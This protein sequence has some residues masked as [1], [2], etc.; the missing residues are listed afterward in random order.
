LYSRA[1]SPVLPQIEEIIGP[2]ASIDEQDPTDTPM[3]AEGRKEY[4]I[5]QLLRI[6]QEDE[7]LT[8]AQKKKEIQLIIRGSQAAF[9]D[10]E[11]SGLVHI[12]DDSNQVT[13]SD[14]AEISCLLPCGHK[15]DNAALAGRLA[16]PI[17]Q[18]CRTSLLPQ[19]AR[20]VY[21]NCIGRHLDLDPD[22][23][24]DADTDTDKGK[25]V[26][27]LPSGAQTADA[28]DA[29][30]VTITTVTTVNSAMWTVV[31]HFSAAWVSR[32]GTSFSHLVDCSK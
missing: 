27:S 1:P 17:C 15:Y 13:S 3:K 25:E 29:T 22:A 8:T 18:T 28:T 24:A 31:A 5:R 23:D 30:D 2:S 32:S 11:D 19:D 4:Y 26:N 9:H 10:S 12:P 20:D 7:V 21:W 6:V 14:S 16:E